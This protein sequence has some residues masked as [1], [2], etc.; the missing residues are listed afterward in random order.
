VHLDDQEIITFL[1][2]DWIAK[3]VAGV[4]QGCMDFDASVLDNVAMG[5]A[6]LGPG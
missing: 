1:D 5:L 3:H 6:A 4:T 2:N